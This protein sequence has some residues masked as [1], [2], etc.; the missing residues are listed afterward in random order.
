MGVLQ[1]R[2]PFFLIPLVRSSTLKTSLAKT[3]SLLLAMQQK[4]FN[5]LW[6]AFVKFS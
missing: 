1:I 3:F 4:H 2:I 6:G 5:D